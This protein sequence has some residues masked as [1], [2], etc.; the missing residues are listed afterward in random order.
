MNTI[1]LN[2]VL[3]KF[4]EFMENLYSNTEKGSQIATEK[5]Y[6]LPSLNDY[7]YLI[8]S[9]LN[10]LIPNDVSL[11]CITGR[12][13]TK[14]YYP[15]YFILVEAIPQ[16]GMYNISIVPNGTNPS[17]NA[18]N[19]SV[20]QNDLIIIL[21]LHALSGKVSISELSENATEITKVRDIVCK[22]PLIK[23]S[24]LPRP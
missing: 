21:L 11:C 18:C 20:S 24:M 14:W 7:L 17:P 4:L 12:V 15:N 16:E 2:N 13:H 9:F 10:I 19:T 3:P 5:G 23:A 1:E 22:K 6:H 8:D